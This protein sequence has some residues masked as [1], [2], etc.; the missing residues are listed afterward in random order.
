M[1]AVVLTRMAI[2]ILIWPMAA[3]IGAAAIVAIGILLLATYPLPTI[4]VVVAVAVVA[5]AAGRWFRARRRPPA[6]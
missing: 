6:A 5:T 3:I 1:D 4:G 2:G